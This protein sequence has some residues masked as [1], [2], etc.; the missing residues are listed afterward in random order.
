MKARVR[1]RHQLVDDARLVGRIDD[2]ARPPAG[3]QALHV[4]GTPG[5]EVVEERHLVA[6]P[7][8]LVRKMR[9]DEARPA[10]N[11]MPQLR[12]PT[13]RATCTT[14]YAS[15]AVLGLYRIVPSTLSAP[16][17][18]RQGDAPPRL[19]ISATPR[20]SPTLRAVR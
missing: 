17:C 6:S 4:L 3:E 5:A 16:H 15:V 19:L 20:S 9:A 12:T 2:Q 11:Q 18:P 13:S 7:G 10:S 14:P 1:V 8:Q